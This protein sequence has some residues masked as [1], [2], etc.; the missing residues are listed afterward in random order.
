MSTKKQA[1]DSKTSR[2]KTR[3]KVSR[4]KKHSQRNHLASAKHS[5]ALL[6]LAP[7][8]FPV[9]YE[10]MIIQSARIGG[11]AFVFF[12]MLFTYSFIESRATNLIVDATQTAS[13]ISA[14]LCGD[15]CTN[16]P[17]VTPAVTF[18]YAQMGDNLY[19]ILADV[20]KAESVT[21]YAYETR[22]QTY[23]QLGSATKQTDTEWGYV[24]E[25]SEVTPGNYWIKAIVAN[26][27]GVYDRSDSMYLK[28]K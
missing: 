24:W 15:T 6:A 20:A 14:P 11:F 2:T 21:I 26:R 18:R 16:S 25:T 22:T 8:K 27:Y 10:R 12:A 1:S 7:Y 9:D 23:H 19:F 4:T 5:L 28:I 3:S 17:V 13:A